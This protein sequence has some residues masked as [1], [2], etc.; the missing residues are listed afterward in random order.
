MISAVWPG[1]CPVTQPWGCTTL[2]LEPPDP[3][4]PGG[5]FHPGIDIGM[6]VGTPLFAARGGR[7][8]TISWGLLGITVGPEVDWYV[9]I[10]GVRVGVGVGSN[11]QAGQLVAASG[12]KVPSGGSITGPHLHFETQRGGL[13]NPYTSVNPVPILE[14]AMSPTDVK[15]VIL[16]A[17]HGTGQGL[18]VTQAQVDAWAAEYPAKPLDVIIA[19]I[20]NT[21]AAIAYRVAVAKAIAD[22][23]PPSTPDDDSLY[24][25]KTHTHTTG[26][27]I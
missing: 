13:N 1:D 11:V 19:A 20:V 2:V 6:A 26:P 14:G 3:A 4:C 12:G 17:V 21:P 5:H 16:A 8:T 7:V 27:A 10:D 9:H 18:V 25:L 22:T 15:G 23:E 24:A